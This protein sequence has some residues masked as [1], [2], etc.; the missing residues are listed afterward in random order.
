MGKRHVC[1]LRDSKFFMRSFI[2][3]AGFHIHLASHETR[4][5]EEDSELEI[6]FQMSRF[7]GILHGVR[8][9]FSPSDMNFV[10]ETM[11]TCRAFT[12]V[13]AEGAIKRKHFYRKLHNLIMAVGMVDV[14]PREVGGPGHNLLL[15]ALM[16][17]PE[18][19]ELQWWWLV[20][21]TLLS[22]TK[23]NRSGSTRASGVS[24]SARRMRL[25]VAV[26][27]KLHGFGQSEAVCRP[28]W[29]HEGRLKLASTNGGYL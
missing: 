7:G 22:G 21:E 23:Q 26:R 24:C 20:L 12:A 25:H 18:D 29:R 5:L 2:K 11:R 27:W 6:L 13:G 14:L 19:T 17:E 28:D 15:E 10:T 4:N 3:L 8:E 9:G 1:R 16:D